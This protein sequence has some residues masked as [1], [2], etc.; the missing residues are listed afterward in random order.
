MATQNQTPDPAPVKSPDK[1][2]KTGYYHA[3]NTTP[4]KFTVIKE[5]PAQTTGRDENNK[6]IIQ[7][8]T[9]DIGNPDGTVA[10]RL[11]PVSDVPK[12]GHFTIGTLPEPDEADE[13]DF[14]AEAAKNAAAAEAEAKRLAALRK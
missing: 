4:V 2:A 13:I 8:R 5:N 9:V 6:P 12:A 10:V 3:A 1:S 7:P 11:C 14:E